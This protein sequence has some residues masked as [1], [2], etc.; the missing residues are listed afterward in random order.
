M[1]HV[2]DDYRNAP[3]L[4]NHSVWT[5][6]PNRTYRPI[7][8]PKPGNESIKG[9]RC[10]SLTWKWSA[11]PATGS[12]V[13]PVVQEKTGD[14]SGLQLYTFDPLT[15]VLDPG[16]VPLTWGYRDPAPGNS[17]HITLCGAMNSMH[18]YWGTM[19]VMVMM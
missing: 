4:P 5:A 15:A 10:G 9:Y 12:A 3:A 2:G 13:L 17:P 6:E 8:P 14:R 19:E 1:T 16:G 7:T 11:V 18:S